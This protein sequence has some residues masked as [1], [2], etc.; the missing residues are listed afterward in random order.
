MRVPLLDVKA[1]YATIREPLLQAVESVLASGQ[2]ILG[3]AVRDLEERLARYLAVPHAVGVASGTDALLVALRALDCGPG[4]EVICP[5]YSFFATAGAISNNGAR[6]VFVD[7]EEATF[8]LNPN[9]LE[10]VITPRTRAVMP[11]HLFGQSAD[12][13]PIMDCC[14]KRGI[15]VIEDAAQ[16][17]GATWR[18]IPVGGVGD[19]GCFSFYPSKN[20]GGAGDGG[21]ITTRRDDLAD[22]V[23]ML[24]THGSRER[25]KHERVGFN[26]R[27]DSVQAAIL[28]VKL[29]HLDSWTAARASH[30]SAYTQAFADLDGLITPIDAGRG[31]HVWNQ[32]TLRVRRGSRDGLRSH[33]SEKGIGSDVYYPIPLHLQECFADLGYRKGSLPVSEAATRESLSIPVYPELTSDQQ[34]YVVETILNWCHD[35]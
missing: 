8:N 3:P 32:Y 29:A 26:S 12:M 14:G 15:P 18:D 25:Y 19:L 30:A 16:A 34:G 17:I 4:T 10:Q 1:Q 27:L 5:A 20:L 31:K 7:I 22:R 24:R 2:W 9:A 6:P 35:N 11:V 23:R 28:G 21:L 13:A 33:L